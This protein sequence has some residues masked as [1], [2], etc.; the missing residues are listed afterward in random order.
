MIGI[1]ALLLAGL[2]GL[3][4][5]P[6]TAETAAPPGFS[7]SWER[8]PDRSD[9]AQEKM[10]AAFQRMQDEMERRGGGGFPGP[11][12]PPPGGPPPGGRRGGGA[13]GAGRVPEELEVEHDK[14]ELRLDDGER[15]QIFYL[16]G[17]KHRREMPNGA[18][19]ETV[20]T[21]QGRTVL[22][23]EKLDKGKI[24]RK[25]ELSEDGKSMVMTLN[26]KIGN[27]KEPVL[28]RT[29]YERLQ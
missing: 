5:Q 19:L 11:G 28:I 23:Q 3:P 2:S 17:Q 14:G 22:I 27:M 9:D 12:G 4:Q 21:L 24:E 26:I 29:V 20:A 6:S 1:G 7:G 13:A 15:L 18:K 25:L 16:D 8:D 10:R